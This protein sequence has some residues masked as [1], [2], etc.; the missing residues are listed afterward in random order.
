MC[1]RII[2]NFMLRYH[3]DYYRSRYVCSSIV[4]SDYLI[5]TLLSVFWVAGVIY[6]T[7]EEKKL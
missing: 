2:N 4:A 1:R 7:T 6:Q 5:T 3:Y